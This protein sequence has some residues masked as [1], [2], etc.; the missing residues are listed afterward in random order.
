[1]SSDLALLDRHLVEAPRE[2]PEWKSVGNSSFREDSTLAE[3]NEARLVM[4]YEMWD[5]G[6][7]DGGTSKD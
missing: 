7:D 2:Q 6:D 5:D 4:L 1:M 3:E